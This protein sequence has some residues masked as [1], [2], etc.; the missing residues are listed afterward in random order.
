MRSTFAV[1]ARFSTPLLPRTLVNQEEEIGW[2]KLGCICSACLAVFLS[3]RHSADVVV[4]NLCHVLVGS[5]GVV[6]LPLHLWFT[7]GLWVLCR[8]L[9]LDS[10][11]ELQRKARVWLKREAQTE[12]EMG[13]WRRERESKWHWANKRKISHTCLFFWAFKKMMQG[14][15]CLSPFWKGQVRSDRYDKLSSNSQKEKTR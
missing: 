7:G 9:M 8:A 15:S 3:A 10:K 2:A 12:G 13:G 14:E 5:V 4:C 6:H 11:A 1:F